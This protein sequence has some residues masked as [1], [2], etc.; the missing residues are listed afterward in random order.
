M[1]VAPGSLRAKLY[2]YS[3]GTAGQ[4]TFMDGGGRWATGENLEDTQARPG[5]IHG[6]NRYFICC[7]NDGGGGGE[8]G[9]GQ[10]GTER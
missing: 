5:R 10:L 6:D 3:L 7:I 2:C 9:D 8:E 1:C 4:Y